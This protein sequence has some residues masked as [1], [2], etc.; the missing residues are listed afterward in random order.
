[1]KGSTRYRLRVGD[2]RV[3]Y[4]FDLRGNAIHLLAV[5]PRREVYKKIEFSGPRFRTRPESL[6][7]AG[8]PTC[9]TRAESDV[10]RAR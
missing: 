4:S 10:T 3:I 7:T 6:L 2:Y 8:P 1:M 9:F 5:G